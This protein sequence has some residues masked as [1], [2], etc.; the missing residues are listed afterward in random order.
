MQGGDRMYTRTLEG[1]DGFATIVE[2]LDSLDTLTAA[3]QRHTMGK[4]I[5]F[6]TPQVQR[7]PLLARDRD[8]G[9]ARLLEELGQ[10]VRRPVPGARVFKQCAERVLGALAPPAPASRACTAPVRR[11]AIGQ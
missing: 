2:M 6:L 4:V 10:E 7:R 11:L 3:G 1:H 8:R 5:G 9:I